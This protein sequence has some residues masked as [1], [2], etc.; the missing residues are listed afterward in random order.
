MGILPKIQ[1]GVGAS[2]TDRLDSYTEAFSMAN[3]FKDG[4][5]GVTGED[6]MFAFCNGNISQ[7]T[8]VWYFNYE[9]MFLDEATIQLNFNEDNRRDSL[10]TIMYYLEATLQWPF[11]IVYS[12]Y[13][14]GVE[15]YLPISMEEQPNL[16]PKIYDENGELVPTHW[17]I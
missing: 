9:N 2:I 4:I 1:E 15:V 14:S 3:G 6:S 12:C 10:R 11:F 16:I 7:T 5:V 8:D 13:W 17:A